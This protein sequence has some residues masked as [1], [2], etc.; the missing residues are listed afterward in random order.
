MKCSATDLD[1]FT[2][3]N[4]PPLAKVGI[5]IRFHISNIRQYPGE[6]R[7]LQVIESLSRNVVMLRM[8]PSITAETVES[9]FKPPIEG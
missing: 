8:F 4:Y 7:S 6:G 9:F 5:D 2:S 1:A 3:P